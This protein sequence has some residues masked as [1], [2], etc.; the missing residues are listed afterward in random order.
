M[1]I[2]GLGTSLIEVPLP[3][4]VGTAIH[5]MRSV[6]CVL[7]EL[8]TDDG[9]VGQSYV[10]TLNAARLHAFDQMIRGFA[11]FVVGRDP[12]ETEGVP[13]PEEKSRPQSLDHRF[14]GS[15]A[16]CLKFA[17]DNVLFL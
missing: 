3:R 10:F 14:C 7:V 9:L 16:N 13:S 4:P 1:R 6:G 2:V 5:A 8:R 12:H 15:E 17:S 11:S